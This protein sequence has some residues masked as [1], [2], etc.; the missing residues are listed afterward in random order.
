MCKQCVTPIHFSFLE[1]CGFFDNLLNFS[2]L[3]RSAYLRARSFESWTQ[4]RIVLTTVLLELTSLNFYYIRAVRLIY[5]FV[6]NAT[7]IQGRRLLE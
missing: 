2:V 1:E 6:P 4:Q 7:L 5:L 3:E